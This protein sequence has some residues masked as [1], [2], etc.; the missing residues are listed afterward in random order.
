MES[1]RDIVKAKPVRSTRRRVILGLATL[2]PV[3]LLG[4]NA[5]HLFSPQRNGWLALTEVLAFFLFL[6]LILLVPF[7]FMKGSLVLRVALALCLLVACVRFFPQL[8][9]AH[10]AENAE[11]THIN[12]MSWNIYVRNKH[13]DEVKQYLY[14][15]PAEIVALHE[16]DEHWVNSDETLAKVYPYRLAFPSS[17]PPGMAIL[18]AYPI[19]G[20]SALDMRLPGDKMPRLCWANIEMEKGKTVTVVAGH[21]LPPTSF[22]GKCGLPGCFDTSVRDTQISA[23]R[24]QAYISN[25]LE[26]GQP[27]ILMGD[28]NITDREP[29]Y[30]DLS[31][32]L[33]DVFLRVGA[34]SGTTWGPIELMNRGISLVRIDYMFSS[35]N[36]TPISMSVDCTSRGSDHCLVKGRFEI[37]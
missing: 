12:V 20:R 18:S 22:S 34:G 37:K 30:R 9:L 23:L 4:L 19:V 1:E 7:A 33:Q 28:F 24:S 5:V 2:Y 3:A 26:A 8:G 25:F 21:P 32:G 17:C 16:V 35:P 27:L 10:P 31:A 13:L 29:A 14:A 6:P 15:K 36:I 11:A